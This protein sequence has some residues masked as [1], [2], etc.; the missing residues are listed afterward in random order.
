LENNPISNIP[1]YRST[2]IFKFRYIK[3]LDGHRVTEEEKRLS[4]KITKKEEEK[5]KENERITQKNE[6]K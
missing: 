3:I 4:Y 1:L 5:R 6:E 2:I